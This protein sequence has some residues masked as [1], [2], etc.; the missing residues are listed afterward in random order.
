MIHLLKSK[1]AQFYVTSKG[2]NGEVLAVSETLKTRQ[3]AWKNIYAQAAT[4]KGSDFKVV[5]ET[6]AKPV[7]YTI[8]SEGEE[9]NK[10]ITI[11]PK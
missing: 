7:T 3:A 6:A 9:F 11:K 5:D 10:W 4:F 8:I 1:D 2:S